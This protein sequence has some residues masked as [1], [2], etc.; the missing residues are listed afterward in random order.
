MCFG[1]LQRGT[2]G[3][4]NRLSDVRA[5]SCRSDSLPRKAD[6]EAVDVA[7]VQQT[8]REDNTAVAGGGGARQAA[9]HGTWWAQC[10]LLSDDTVGRI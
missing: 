4:N 6:T 3:N 9:Q 7:G 10:L 2:H 8:A 5:S 1:L